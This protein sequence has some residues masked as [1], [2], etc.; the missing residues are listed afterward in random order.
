ME[1]IE[2]HYRLFPLINRSIWKN[3]VIICKHEYNKQAVKRYNKR[4]TFYPF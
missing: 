4:K 3:I 2:T 1:E